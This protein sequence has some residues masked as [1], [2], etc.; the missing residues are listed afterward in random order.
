MLNMKKLL[1][2]ILNSIKVDYIVEEGSKGTYGYYRKWNSGKAEYWYHYNVTGVTTAVWVA[3][4][5]YLDSTS[6]GNIWSG[7]FNRAPFSVTASSNFSQFISI[8]PYSYSETGILSLRFLS[9]GAKTNY[10]VPI[11]IYAYGTWK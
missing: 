8:V 4:I 5:Y 2:K 11:S 1:T 7:I 10:T 3:P 6:F 9:V